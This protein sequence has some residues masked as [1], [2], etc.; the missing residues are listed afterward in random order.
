M[1][2]SK[3]VGGMGFQDMHW[4]NVALVMKQAWKL[5]REEKS[6]AFEVLKSK[7]FPNGC[8]SSWA[9]TLLTFVGAFR[10]LGPQPFLHLEEH[11]GSR[12]FLIKR[13]MLEGWKWR[14]NKNLAR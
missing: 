7:Y 3:S 5:V 13:A 4:F 6:L 11:L 2:T 14:E 9:T 8:F 12:G 1:C 10:K